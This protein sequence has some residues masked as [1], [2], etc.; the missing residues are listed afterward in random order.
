MTKQLK[1]SDVH[2]RASGKDQIVT[3]KSP[4]FIRDNEEYIFHARIRG[5]EYTVVKI[6]NTA[7]KE[8]VQVEQ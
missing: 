1:L 4:Y 8:V 3:A 2:L 5:V 7:T 6:V